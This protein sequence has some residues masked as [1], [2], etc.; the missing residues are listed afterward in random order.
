MT[1][2]ISK[3]RALREFAGKAWR[4]SMPYYLHSEDKWK[5]RGLLLAIVLLNLGA[6]YM[7]VLLNEWNRVF[8]DALQNKDAAV[9][10]RELGRFTY[11]AFSFI[12]IAVYRFYLTQL[13]Q[14]RWRE[15][16]TRH[17]MDRWLANHRFYQM[18]LARYSREG[19]APPDNP[20]QRIAEDMNL[21]TSYT[22][23]L[24]MGLLNAVVTLL[25]FIGILWTLSGSF[26]FTFQGRHV[27]IPGFMV[28]MAVL[29]CV[30]GSVLAHYIGRPQIALNFKQQRFEADFRHHLVRVREYSESIA[31][32]KGE[33]VERRQLGLRF[34][35]VLGNYLRLIRTQKRLVWFTNGFGQAATVF[36]FIVAAPRFFS[37]AIQLGELMQIA[38]AFDRVQG[39]LS[40]FVDNYDQIAAWRA[41]TD[42]I[43]SFDESFAALQAGDPAT[44]SETNAEDAI[45]LDAMDLA[46]PGGAALL[47][48][49]GARIAPGDS[50]LVQGPSGSGK[51]TLFRGLAG[52]WPWATRRLRLPADFDARAMFLPQRPYFPNGRLR[53]AL[54]YPEPAARYGD[55]ELQAALR[56]ALLPDLVARLDDPDAWGQKL[57]GGEQQR[58]AIARALLKKPRWLFVDEATSALDEAAEATIYERLQALVRAQNG[59]L[60]SIAHRP[61]VAD[62]HARRWVLQP[63]AADGP[64]YRVAT[65]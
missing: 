6:V 24:S 41:T 23:G 65:G 33:G 62:W 43:T 14:M 58:L 11:L 48:V 50:V 49:H 31:L 17:Y 59:A 3:W 2:K 64:R 16:M 32:D 8:Y 10:W 18:E 13:L 45:A 39:A 4:L 28:W 40:W 34:A 38:S 35:D 42:R 19:N 21:F 30:I 27:D 5:A 54:A 26:G 57:S 60:V 36:P 51:S 56:E 46:L 37:G 25:S 15:W 52:I 44:A 22:V 9:F 63:G 47:A 12:I 61:G 53:D 20:D 55:E 29:Y 7:L 1:E